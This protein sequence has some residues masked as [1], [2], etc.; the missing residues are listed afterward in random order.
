[1]VTIDAL[2]AHADYSEMINWLSHLKRPPRKT[3]IVHG[4]PHSQDAFR[5]HIKD[6]L[7]WQAT[8]PEQG[9]SVK[10]D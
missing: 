5:R 6:S 3:F 4:E 8:I 2:S 10:L 9:D 1:L 7:G